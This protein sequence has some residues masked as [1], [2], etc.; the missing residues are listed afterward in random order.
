MAALSHFISRLREKGLPFFKLLKKS[1]KFEWTVEAD[2]TFQKLKEYLSTSM[3]LTPPEKREPLLL[4]IAATT[5]VVSMA[6]VMEQAEDGHVYKVQWPIYYISEA[7]A[8][9]K[10]KNP[11]VQK[12]LYALFITSRKLCH[13]FDEHKETVVSDFLLGDV[14]CIW[15]VIGRIC[16]WSVKLRAQNIEF[17]SRKAIKYQVLAD[18]TAEWTKA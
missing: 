18:F 10:A 8:E 6:I 11:H 5:M 15:D 9:S 7:L 4:Y 2:E 14:L 3:I 17:V 1:G 16:K 12:L 13:Y